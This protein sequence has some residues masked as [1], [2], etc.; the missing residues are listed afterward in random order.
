MIILSFTRTSFTFTYN[1]FNTKEIFVI[2]V[3]CVDVI[4]H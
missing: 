1:L 2:D 3:L 4:V